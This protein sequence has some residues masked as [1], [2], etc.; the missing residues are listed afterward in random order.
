MLNL[1]LYKKHHLRGTL[2]SL[3][4]LRKNSLERVQVDKTHL[5]MNKPKGIFVAVTAY[6]NEQLQK[7]WLQ[8]NIWIHVDCVAFEI[9]Y[10]EEKAPQQL[11]SL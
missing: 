8:L 1:R 3:H 6:F 10:T 9:R 5:L 4:F 11:N 2:P 7:L